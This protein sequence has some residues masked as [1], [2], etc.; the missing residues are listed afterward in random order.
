MPSSSFRSRWAL[1][2]GWRREM[3]FQIQHA[4]DRRC[5]E[6]R[7][8]RGAGYRLT[9]IL[10]PQE[11]ALDVLRDR[12]ARRAHRAHSEVLQLSPR[13]SFIY[14]RRDRRRQAV[15]RAR[16]EW[17][18]DIILIEAFG[19]EAIPVHLLT[20]G[21]R[22]LNSKAQTRRSGRVS[23]QQPLPRSRGSHLR[24]RDER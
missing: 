22:R 15:T 21:V 7:W 10:W 6:T 11:R 24:R 19:S 1:S 5:I 4:H 16:T 13:L 12:P 3:G 9:R 8:D 18:V 20:R 17:G 23:R 14:G 2:S